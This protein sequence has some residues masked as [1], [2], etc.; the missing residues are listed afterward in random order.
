MIRLIIVTV[1]GVAILVGCK[2]LGIEPGAP[3]PE[4]GLTNAEYNVKTI[5]TA[6]WPLALLATKFIPVVGPLVADVAWALLATKKQK[7]ED[8]GKPNA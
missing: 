4:D 6:A 3:I 8:Q 2:R 5:A 1:V 7:L